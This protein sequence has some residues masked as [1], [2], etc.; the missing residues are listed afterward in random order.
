VMRLLE[1]YPALRSLPARWIGLG[2]RP[3]HIQ[4]APRWPEKEP[5]VQA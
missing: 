5:P 1:R 4:T 2:V 3:E